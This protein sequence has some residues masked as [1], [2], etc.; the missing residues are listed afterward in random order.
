MSLTDDFLF[1]ISDD[2]VTSCSNHGKTLF[3]FGPSQICY[4]PRISQYLVI[5]NLYFLEIHIFHLKKHLLLIILMCGQKN[6]K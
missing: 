3:F 1:F 4:I 5:K 6:P 2:P